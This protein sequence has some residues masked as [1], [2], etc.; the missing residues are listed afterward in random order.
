MRSRSVVSRTSRVKENARPLTLGRTLKTASVVVPPPVRSARKPLASASVVHTVSGGAAAAAPAAV[1][2]PRQPLF[3]RPTLEAS[4]LPSFVEEIDRVFEH[5][6]YT[7]V[8]SVM[9]KSK[10]PGVDFKVRSR[11]GVVWVGGDGGAMRVPPAATRHH[12]PR[13]DHEAQG[14]DSRACRATRRAWAPCAGVLWLV[15]GARQPPPHWPVPRQSVEE[16]VISRMAEVNKLQAGVGGLEATKTR[17]EGQLQEARDALV[18]ANRSVR[19]GSVAADGA[20]TAAGPSARVPVPVPPPPQTLVAQDNERIADDER[21]ELAEQVTRLEAEVRWV[22]RGET[23]KRPIEATTLTI[24]HSS[25]R[26][27]KGAGGGRARAVR[28]RCG[29]RR[30]GQGTARPGTLDDGGE[31][32]PR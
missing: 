30:D 31:G 29:R 27:G 14:H 16:A 11:A 6:D 23:G 13:D 25:A 1:A 5:K 8:L 18:T 9:W 12:D 19:V 17:L 2:A 10:P 32:R 4:G 21:A 7:S 26:R 3:R 20:T 22:M 28:G 24:A 15:Y